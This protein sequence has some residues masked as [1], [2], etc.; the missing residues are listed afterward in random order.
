MSVGEGLALRPAGRVVPGG[1]K[2]AAMKTALTM[3]VAAALTALSGPAAAQ[4]Q[5]RNDF[6]IPLTALETTK[7]VDNR[8]IV[9]TLKGKGHYRKLSLNTDCTGLKL[10]DGFSYNTSLP[11]LCKGDTIT[12]IGSI[13]SVCG[14]ADITAIDDNEAKQLLATK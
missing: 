6:C 14:I 2:V 13:G 3:V 10:Q 1:E 5:Q 11:A 4:V 8:T 7:A 9:A 12:V